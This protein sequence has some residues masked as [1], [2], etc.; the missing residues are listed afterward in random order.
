MSP[1]IF[2]FILGVLKQFML[3]KVFK[4]HGAI[5]YLNC[6]NMK[7]NLFQYK[8]QPFEKEFVKM[9]VFKFPI[10]K[11]LYLDHRRLYPRRCFCSV[12]HISF[13]WYVFAWGE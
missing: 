6:F 5:I 9:S 13:S 3:Q 8:L 1:E 10:L 12:F 2:N 7:I 4:K 11:F